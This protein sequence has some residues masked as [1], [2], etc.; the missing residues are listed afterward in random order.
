MGGVLSLDRPGQDPERGLP[1]GLT[2]KRHQAAQID[3]AAASNR[4]SRYEIEQ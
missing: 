2:V 1:G 4:L 3:H